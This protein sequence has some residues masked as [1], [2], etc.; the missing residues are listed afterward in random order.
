MSIRALLEISLVATVLTVAA[1]A[2]GTTSEDIVPDRPPPTAGPATGGVSGEQAMGEVWAPIDGVT[3]NVAESFPPQYFVN[4]RSG[5]PNACNEFDRYEVAREGDTVRIT[6][7]NLRPVEPL[8]CAEIYRTVESNVALGSDFEG[9]RTYTLYVNDVTETFVAQGAAAGSTTPGQPPRVSVPAPVESVEVVVMET[10]TV[11]YS[12]EVVSRLPRGS[13]CSEF[14]GYQVALDGT[15][16]VVDVSNLE[17]ADRDVECTADLPIVKTEIPLD[18][19]FAAGET[20]TVVVN[21]QVTNSFVGRDPQ[22]PEMVVKE[23]PIE[24]VQVVESESGRPEY[25]LEVISRLPRGSSCSQFDGYDV[26]RRFAGT[27]AVTVTHLEV[28][29]EL[30]RCTR[31]L[32]VAATTIPLGSDF[33]PGETYT[34]VV[35]GDTTET[36]VAR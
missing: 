36:F 23:S 1:M 9:G 18:G 29:D 27:V 32:P 2:C 19:D 28:S 3:V 8:A 20:Y 31:D 33:T 13:S 6:V 21:G 16:V 4:V 34:V 7:I 25:S 10:E 26:A 17:V 22:G 14:E 5:L 30:A 12:L 11:G 35:N 15:S 24:A